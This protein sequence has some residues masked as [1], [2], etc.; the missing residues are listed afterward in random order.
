MGQQQVRSKFLR[1]EWLRPT[2]QRFKVM[3]LIE[4]NV[5][6][7]PVELDDGEIGLLADGVVYVANADCQIQ[8]YENGELV[9]ESAAP[10]DQHRQDH[11]PRGLQAL[12]ALTLYERA[13]GKPT[14]VGRAW[15]KFWGK[16]ENDQ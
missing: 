6:G 2:G 3:E 16:D 8:L 11:P 4:G 12:A 15:N 5:T 7:E 1:Y 13:L 14:T 10:P 9:A